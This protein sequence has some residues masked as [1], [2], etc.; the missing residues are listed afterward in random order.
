MVTGAGGSIGSE[1]CRQIMKLKPATL[2]LYD[3]NE[4]GLYAIERELQSFDI[5]VPIFAI[6]G[7]VQDQ[8]RIES[9]CSRY[10]INTIYHAAAYKHVPMV[11]RN[12]TEGVRNNV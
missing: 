5:D 7:N 10:A 6:L 9:A 1:L 2:V 8:K 4:F 3:L 11:E 12:T